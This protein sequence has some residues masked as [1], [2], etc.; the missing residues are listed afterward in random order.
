MHPP[1]NNC[2]YGNISSTP[3]QAAAEA[4]VQIKCFI[5]NHF[6]NAQITLL[7]DNRVYTWRLYECLR[8]G[9]IHQIHVIS[10]STDKN[11]LM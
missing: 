5:Y 4:E 3:A 8:N 6:F 2:D 1:G 7:I 11:V 9:D 10:F